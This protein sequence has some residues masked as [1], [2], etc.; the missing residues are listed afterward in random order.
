[1]PDQYWPACSELL[2]CLADALD[3]G[4]PLMPLP[5]F[6]ILRKGPLERRGV[7]QDETGGA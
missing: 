5:S 4:E 1:M 7:T 6:A 2:R 3:A